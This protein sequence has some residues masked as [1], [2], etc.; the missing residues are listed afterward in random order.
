MRKSNIFWKDDVSRPPEPGEARQTLINENATSIQNQKL[1]EHLQSGNTINFLQAK[2]LGIDSLN[3]RIVDL[4]KQGTVVH[5]RV[6]RIN[7]IFCN[8]FGLKSFA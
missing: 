5:T 7:G 8:E 3:T 6:I 1:L 2:D 4:R